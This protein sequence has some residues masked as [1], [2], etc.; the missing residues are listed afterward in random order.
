[1]DGAG[2]AEAYALEQGRLDGP[3]ALIRLIHYGAALRAMSDHVDE[4]LVT[5]PAGPMLDLLDHAYDRFILARTT[6]RAE[7]FT[8]FVMSLMLSLCDD[9]DEERKLR[10]GAARYMV[11]VSSRL[12]RRYVPIVDGARQLLREETRRH[13]SLPSSRAEPQARAALHRP[14]TRA[15][16]HQPQARRDSPLVSAVA[17]VLLAL[18]LGAA[19]FLYLLYST[20]DAVVPEDVRA[21]SAIR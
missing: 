9:P 17:T 11:M 6:L 8:L 7:E 12:P 20:D 15:S 14:A 13:R 2:N 3:D 5:G 4:R 21:H 10:I 18:F 1:M 19:S 16:G